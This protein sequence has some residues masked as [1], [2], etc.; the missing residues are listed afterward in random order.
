MMLH[1]LQAD[2]KVVTDAKGGAF[3]RDHLPLLG[4]FLF[5]E[6][7]RYEQQHGF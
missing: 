5:F 4:N 7:C 1:F 2:L 6:N 3:Y